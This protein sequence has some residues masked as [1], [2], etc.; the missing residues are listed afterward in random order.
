MSFIEHTT[1]KNGDLY[2]KYFLAD[3][4][5]TQR[6]VDNFNLDTSDHKIE[7]IENTEN[8]N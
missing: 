3:E 8:N 1:D 7:N 6:Q 5:L 2:L 4:S